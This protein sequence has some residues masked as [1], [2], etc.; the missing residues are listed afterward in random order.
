LSIPVRL[1]GWKKINHAGKLESEEG[2]VPGSIS[3]NLF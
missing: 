2:K 1:Q 3:G